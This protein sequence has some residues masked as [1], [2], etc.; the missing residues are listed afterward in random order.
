MALLAHDIGP[1]DEVITSPF[2]FAATANTIVM[3]GARPVFVDIDPA[4]YNIDPALIEA[5]ITPRTKAIM[6]VHLYGQPADMDA[7]CAIALRHQ[8]SIIEDA[9]QAVGATYRERP[10]GNFGTACFSLYATK[11]ITTA[12]GGMVVTDEPLVVD[13]LKLLRA[14]GMRVRYYHETLGYNYRLTDLQAAIGLAQFEKLPLFNERRR[15]NAAYLSAHINHPDVI[16][17]FV[18]PLVQHVFHQYTVRILGDRDS[19]AKQLAAAGVG[20]AIFYPITIPQQQYYRELGYDVHLPHS[21]R[22]A[23][24]VLA[25]PVHP[26]LSEQELQQIV[27]AVNNLARTEGPL[28]LAAVDT[29]TAVA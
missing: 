25:L 17:P 2:S 27:T 3:T 9:A 15:A 4:T 21:E 1:G 12:E 18:S 14:H 10:A 29:A 22:A 8:L 5:A 19:A 23:R 16:K 26:A 28:G 24:E 11:N 13:R 6:P 20:T 7:I